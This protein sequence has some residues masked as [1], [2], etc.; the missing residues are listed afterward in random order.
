MNINSKMPGTHRKSIL[1]CTDAEIRAF[2][3]AFTIITGSVF[4]GSFAGKQPGWLRWLERLFCAV[5]LACAWY[6][7]LRELRRRRRGG[8]PQEFR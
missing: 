2:L 7:S 5:C 8:A 1:E 4:V 6:Q 3:I